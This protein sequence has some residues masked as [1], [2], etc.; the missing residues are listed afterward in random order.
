MSRRT[1]VTA[2]V[3]LLML[4]QAG[5]AG[6]CWWL[7][8]NSDR[9]LTLEIA[10]NLDLRRR[11][12]EAP[13]APAVEMAP[14]KSRWRLHESNDVPATM[15]LLEGMCDGDGVVVDSI[16]AATTNAPGRQSYLLAVHGS[17]SA[18]CALLVS[19]ENHEQLLLIENGRIRPGPDGT[20][21]ADL[22]VCA[23]HGGDQ[24]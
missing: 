7:R 8:E 2:F 1:L 20:L 22:G 10:N 23:V 17:P 6:M 14:P 12:E 19:L 9:E 15:Q 13:P 21:A 16:K 4:A 11:A 18:L 5:A 24:R 3:V